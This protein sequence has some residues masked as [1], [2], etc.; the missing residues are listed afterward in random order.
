[1]L[2]HPMPETV[3]GCGRDTL[4]PDLIVIAAE[5]SMGHSKIAP[6]SPNIMRRSGAF[7]EIKLAIGARGLYASAG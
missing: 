5:H 3:A 7:R 6:R 1:M 2:L 4:A